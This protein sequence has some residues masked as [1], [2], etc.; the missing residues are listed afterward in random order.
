MDSSPLRKEL[1]LLTSF[2]LDLNKAIHMKRK[3]LAVEACGGRQT[4]ASGVWPKYEALG[5]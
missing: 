4:P 3:T 5:L 1:P 2:F